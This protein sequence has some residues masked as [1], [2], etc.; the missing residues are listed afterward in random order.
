M[1]RPEDYDDF[2]LID[3][4]RVLKHGGRFRMPMAAMDS[5]QHAIAARFDELRDGLPAVLHRPGYVGASV[6]LG[7]AAAAVAS[8]AAYDAWKARLSNAWKE[9]A[10]A[11]PEE[12][13]VDSTATADAAR[14]AYDRMVQKLGNAWRRK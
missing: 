8:R 10:T 12:T 3:G 1:Y 4:K 6:G 11:R 2:E 5:M 13:R 9:P 7:D 14:A